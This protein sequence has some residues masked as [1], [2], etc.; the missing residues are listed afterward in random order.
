MPGLCCSTWDLVSC[1]GIKL[2][3]PALGARCSTHW[4]TREVPTPVFSPGKSHGQRSL[5]GYSPRGCKESDLATKQN[6][7][8][9]ILWL[10]SNKKTVWI[11]LI[12]YIRHS[13][14]SAT[15][16]WWQVRNFITAGK[17]VLTLT[18]GMRKVFWVL[19]MFC[20]NLGDTHRH[21]HLCIHLVVHLWVL[22][23]WEYTIKISL[24]KNYKVYELINE[25]NHY[26]SFLLLHNR[27]PQV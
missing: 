12:S 26:S 14:M 6:Q 11:L 22:H 1:P 8:N 17:E 5:V 16:Q 2:R 3:L 20:I 21:R 13:S 10:N 4:T 15:N 25:K 19:E 7:Q 23:M 18:S 24:H 9:M 27:F